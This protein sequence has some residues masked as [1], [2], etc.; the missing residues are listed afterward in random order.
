MTKKPEIELIKITF[1]KEGKVAAHPSLGP[2]LEV[3]KDEIMLVEKD[4][5][6]HLIDIEWAI[7]DDDEQL[8]EEDEDGDEEDEEENAEEDE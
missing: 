2:T 3:T 1:I 7:L 8:D 5:A 6:Q 4:A